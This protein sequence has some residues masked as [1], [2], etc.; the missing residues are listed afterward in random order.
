M[1]FNVKNSENLFKR[2]FASN[3]HARDLSFNDQAMNKFKVDLNYG[4]GNGDKDNNRVG[5]SRN[6]VDTTDSPYN[7]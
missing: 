6:K 5:N 1:L 3:K 4:Y 7:I 2:G